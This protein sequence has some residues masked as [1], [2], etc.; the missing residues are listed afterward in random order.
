[1]LDWK[2]L[3]SLQWECQNEGLF[4]RR[5]PISLIF[6]LLSFCNYVF[7]MAF[8]AN[9]DS[10]YKLSTRVRERDRANGQGLMKFACVCV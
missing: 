2:E 1:M 3:L 4:L 5:G 9:D 6:F 10:L 8:L 7:L